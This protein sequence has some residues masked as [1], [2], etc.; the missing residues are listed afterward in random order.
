MASAPTRRSFDYLPLT[1]RLETAGGVATPLVLRGTPLP[2][3]RSERFSTAADRQVSVSVELSIGESS[4][5]RNNIAIGKFQLEGLPPK[6]RGEPQV[7]VTFSVDKHCIIT[8]EARLDGSELSATKQFEV[9]FDLSEEKIAEAIA[10]A[11]ANRSADER[12]TLR[13]EVTNRAKDILQK[14]EERLTG[15]PN[16]KLSEAIAELGLA[17]ASDDS[18]Q[19]RLKTDTLQ[20]MLAAPGF[21]FFS[22]PSI[23]K[24]VFN[25]PRSPGKGTRARPSRPRVPKET[26]TPNAPP[27]QLGKLFG[28]ATFT[29]NP[30]LCFVLMPF[31]EKYRPLYEDHIRPSVTSAGLLCERADDIRGMNLITWDIWERV[32]RAR[33]LIADLTDQNPNVFYE[34]G[35]A[36]AI[37]KDVILITQSEDFVPFDLKAIRWIKYDFTPRGTPRS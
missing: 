21:D 36:H 12:E 1:V 25:V 37:S 8:A 10:R 19:I 7:T 15:G 23:F 3:V 14:A 9:P 22:D 5:V 27:H 31:A 35:L 26:L 32:N 6:K 30:Q 2:T 4:M 33:F 18:E 28:G 11:E 29:L 24:N 16:P 17:L 13:V 34:L 20:S